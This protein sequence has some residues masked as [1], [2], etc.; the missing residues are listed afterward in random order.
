MAFKE[1]FKIVFDIDTVKLDKAFNSLTRRTDMFGSQIGVVARK[2]NTQFIGGL[3][4]AVG[5][6]KQFSTELTK[7]GA[8]FEQ[9]I[10]TL[11]AIKGADPQALGAF[12]DEARRLGASTAYTATQAAE[13]MQELA[14]AGLETG[15]I[16]KM[17]GSALEFAGANAIT[18]Q[19]STKL[20]A[21]TMRQFDL[22]AYET[23]QILDTF[24]TATQNSLFDVESLAVAMR[25][26]G[27]VASSL[28]ADLGET[29]AVMSSFR[30]LGLEGSMVGT[31]FRQ[32]LLS[33]AAPTGRAEKLLKEYG[34]TLDELNVKTHGIT[35]V[36]RT[37]A[38]AGLTS[39]EALAPLVS[40][41]AAG[42]MAKIASQLQGTIS[43][44]TLATVAA[45]EFGATLDDLDSDRVPNFGLEDLVYI[46]RRN[47]KAMEMFGKTY[48]E[49]NAD[50]SFELSQNLPEETLKI[51]NAISKIDMMQIKFAKNAG[52]TSRTY[53]DM[54]GTIEGQYKILT[55]AIEEFQIATFKAFNVK[56]INP[57]TSTNAFVGFIEI[58]QMAKEEFDSFTLIVTSNSAYLSAEFT[59]LFEILSGSGQEFFDVDSSEEFYAS[60]IV[61]I[62]NVIDAIEELLAYLPSFNTLFNVGSLAF[63][64]VLADG[65]RRALAAIIQFAGQISGT[66]AKVTNLGLMID[67][68]AKNTERTTVSSA[69]LQFKLQGVI[70]VLLTIAN[71]LEQ[72]VLLMQQMPG[73][74][75]RTSA[76][77][78]KTSMV[79]AGLNSQFVQM[80]AGQT[81]MQ[82]TTAV[83]G[84]T[85]L[86]R[87]KDA[88][89]AMPRLGVAVAKTG[90]GI[91]AAATR[92]TRFLSFLFKGLM[93]PV[94]LLLTTLYLFKDPLV[95]LV[96]TIG[97]YTGLLDKAQTAAENVKLAAEGMKEAID[98]LNKSN[99]ED[100]GGLDIE[101]NEIN[102]QLV[103]EHL[104]SKGE[105]NQT[106]IR[107]LNLSRDLTEEKKKE[108]VLAG[109]LL[110]YTVELNGRS[111]DVLLTTNAVAE[112][113]AT[114]LNQNDAIIHQRAQMVQKAKDLKDELAGAELERLENAKNALMVAQKYESSSIEFDVYMNKARETLG[115]VNKDFGYIANNMTN[116]I[117]GLGIA[118]R[119]VNEQ[120]AIRDKKEEY[121]QKM[122]NKFQDKLE[123]ESVVKKVGRSSRR[124]SKLLELEQKVMRER[125]KVAAQRTKETKALEQQFKIEDL[126][127]KYDEE[128]KY[129]GK[130]RAQMLKIERSF[131]NSVLVIAETTYDRYFQEIRKRRDNILSEGAILM[132]DDIVAIDEEF[133]KN[134]Q[135][136][137]D[138]YQEFINLQQ[139][140]LTE[141]QKANRSR[142][143]LGVRGLGKNEKKQLD[144]ELKDLQEELFYFRDELSKSISAIDV[145]F[146]RERLLTSPEYKAEYDKQVAEVRELY[147]DQVNLFV[148][149]AVDGSLAG[150]DTLVKALP[151][152]TDLLRDFLEDSE[153]QVNRFGE[154]TEKKRTALTEEE[155]FLLI[156]KNKAIEEINK[157]H[158]EE[159]L[160]LQDSFASK[161]DMPFKMMERDKQANLE[162]LK[163]E[164]ATF[165]KLLEFQ[166]AYDDKF[167]FEQQRVIDETARQYGELTELRMGLEVG[168]I[169]GE[170]A[171]KFGVGGIK[172]VFDA[173]V[174]LFDDIYNIQQKF[175]ED[176]ARLDDALVSDEQIKALED[177]IKSYDEELANLDKELQ[178]ISDSQVDLNRQIAT[179][180]QTLA[181]NI[182]YLTDANYSVNIGVEA[183]DADFTKIKEQLKLLEGEIEVKVKAGDNEGAA[184]LQDIYNQAETQ[185]YAKQ[186]EF[187][188]SMGE[189]KFDAKQLLAQKEMLKAG[190]ERL[191]QGLAQK[192]SSMKNVK[193][194]AK[195]LKLQKMIAI[196]LKVVSIT[197]G[198]IV[199]A[200]GMMVKYFKSMISFYKKFVSLLRQ[201]YDFTKKTVDY[202]TG[203]LTFNVFDALAESVDNFISKEDEALGKLKELDDQ[204][205]SR[206]ITEEEYAKAVAGGLGKVDASQIAKNFVNEIY[207]K[208]MQKINAFIKMAPMTFRLLEK[209]IDPIF[210]RLRKAIPR[211]SK[212]LAETVPKFLTTVARNMINFFPIIMEGIRNFVSNVIDEF[213]RLGPQAIIR[214]VEV[215]KDEAI[216]TFDLIAQ[217]LPSIAESLKTIL[218]D[219]LLFIEEL[220]DYLGKNMGQLTPYII[221]IFGTLNKIFAKFVFELVENAVEAVFRSIGGVIGRIIKSIADFTG[222][223]STPEER[224]E[225]RKEFFGDVGDFFKDTFSFGD[226]PGVI[227]AG[228]DGLMARFKA[229]DYVV[230]AQKPEMMLNN[231]LGAFASS[232]KDMVSNVG[233]PSSSQPP[234]MNSN[235]TTNVD[236][237]I[238]AEGRLLDAVQVSAMDRGHAPKMQRKFRRASGVNVGFDRGK[239]NR[240]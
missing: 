5:Q 236:I 212:S 194:A 158:N 215:I 239:F 63:F 67:N 178:S 60:I 106:L 198:V 96:T 141:G 13:G 189:S 220:L 142:V 57:D 69:K 108:L 233:N 124:Q 175:L 162:K 188:Q 43:F 121:H 6:L 161:Y 68:A 27:S 95:D 8:Q 129:F 224:K 107:E 203:G 76:E 97:E 193:A 126:R 85:T 226:T 66:I 168:Q 26:G 105:L 90:E 230:A 156:K 160:E 140:S 51:E 231:V 151:K 172:K 197:V 202:L 117:K 84:A 221:S 98:Q 183:S 165:E 40:K 88:T 94:G 41:R 71:L 52:V 91:A 206:N 222:F 214:I 152:N 119:A 191:K 186:G 48:D 219:V 137:I 167:L 29:V 139:Q 135:D 7:V 18:M 31:R 150:F 163:Q 148:R 73:M 114:E 185:L 65:I 1:N 70:Q 61:G 229:G 179:D 134:M 56:A 16:L 174:G 138:Y 25:Y 9:S 122:V 196:V 115:L 104:L 55:S 128:V 199:A 205:A 216:K 125:L 36:L 171:D 46:I 72:V 4:I 190:K 145:T 204:L 54:I 238:I 213:L 102:A 211:L 146:D 111:T 235:S 237:A 149:G 37:L 92:T 87:V 110:K 180:L 164:G 200:F 15:E 45:R 93:G 59:R 77:F 166:K 127:K 133:N 228:S 109:D 184:E 223:T 147:S 123:K 24:T 100:F 58:L 131:A 22:A 81:A 159:L 14:R 201:G 28:G 35:E 130:S 240:F 170:V 23:T 101:Q 83:F 80:T 116:D 209:I 19:L 113:R 112:L 74:A 39:A 17:T 62:G 75:M 34:I 118:M 53:E 20:L 210:R 21:S 234:P 155:I 30:D 143:T 187:N 154:S 182:I 44:T 208:A 227:Q 78:Q 225:S 173:S 217:A 11:G 181:D 50:Q 10:A 82:G 79:L 195:L 132:G 64:T 144:K 3:Q 120:L 12:S 89:V 33:L 157:K 99:V 177:N 42:S 136:A 153:K 2:I 218:P 47:E 169:V 32:V 49:I 86:K 232:V 38:N 192:L 176:Q 103:K 207:Q